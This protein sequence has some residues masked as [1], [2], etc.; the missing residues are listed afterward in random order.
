MSAG[1]AKNGQLPYII[2]KFYWLENPEKSEKILKIIKKF[3]NAE[4]SAG[5]AKNG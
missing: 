1:I 5:I 4:M 3:P 2:I